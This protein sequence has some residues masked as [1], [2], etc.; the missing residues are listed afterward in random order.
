MTKTEATEKIKSGISLRELDSEFSKDKDIVLAAVKISGDELKFA[1][2]E[3]K[4]DKEIALAAI[5]SEGFP[6]EFISLELWD[7]T[8]FV[9]DALEVYAG[10]FGFVSKRL[11]SD[12]IYVLELMNKYDIPIHALSDELRD[13]E[14]VFL[15]ACKSSLNERGDI[16]FASERLKSSEK[17]ILEAIIINPELIYYANDVILDSEDF[18]KRCLIE[19]PE[20]A[21][22]HLALY[23]YEQISKGKLDLKNVD[24]KHLRKYH[25]IHAII[26]G[27]SL[28]EVDEYDEEIILSAMKKGANIPAEQLIP[29]VYEYQNDA[30]LLIALLGGQGLLLEHLKD[31][32]NNYDAVM[33]AVKNDGI[34]YR[35]ASPELRKNIQV[36]K[37]AVLNNPAA[38]DYISNEVKSNK[39]FLDFIN[40]H[41]PN[42]I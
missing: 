26:N 19:N 38:I 29:L 14:Q 9:E 4:N 24:V 10:C 18:V 23:Y 34:A 28:E 25:K 16:N 20:S 42:G 11:L 31:L 33:A 8:T 40:Q 36:S 13:D 22:Y 5:S 15:E 41:F 2:D 39:E 27:Y 6:F 30:S 32:Q 35:F 37:E 21:E 1:C 7:D 12:K 3:L 17:F